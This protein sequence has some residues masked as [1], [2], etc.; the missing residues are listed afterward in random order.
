MTHLRSVHW[1]F[2]VEG[3]KCGEKI[4]NFLRSVHRCR[5]PVHRVWGRIFLH[6]FVSAGRP[7]AVGEEIIQISYKMAW[8]G[9]PK[10]DPLL[11]FFGPSAT[12]GD[13]IVKYIAFLSPAYDGASLKTSKFVLDIFC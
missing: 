4:V 13:T 10:E 3:P 11:A 7:L 2:G 6:T 9:A 5:K 8:P 1:G 12:P